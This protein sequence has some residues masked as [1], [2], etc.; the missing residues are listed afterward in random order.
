MPG[1]DCERMT[2]TP[3]TPLSRSA[4]GNG[5]ELL[6]L[7]RGQ[8]ERLGLDVCVG[9]CELG[10]HVDRG[11]AQLSDAHDHHAGGECDDASSRNLRLVSTIQ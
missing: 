1:T 11:I 4:S 7:L 6:H 5:D 2:S 8:P 3:S 9:R 10:Q